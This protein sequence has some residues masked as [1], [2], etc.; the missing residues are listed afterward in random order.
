MNVNNPIVAL[1]LIVGAIIIGIAVLFLGLCAV[2]LFLPAILVLVGFLMLWRGS[3][4]NQML[5]AAGMLIV[6]IGIILWLWS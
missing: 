4:G 5:M 6:V 2:S 1:M 3:K